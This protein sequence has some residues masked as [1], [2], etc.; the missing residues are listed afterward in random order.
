MRINDNYVLREIAGE[1]MLVP[2]GA[3]NSINGMI[4]LNEVGASIWKLYKEKADDGY[5]IEKLL[6]IFDVDEAE[7][8]K[9]VALYRQQMEEKGLL[10][11]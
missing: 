3:E 9:D 5:V 10:V 11:P 2:I 7:L 6:E 4:V 1:Y 8:R